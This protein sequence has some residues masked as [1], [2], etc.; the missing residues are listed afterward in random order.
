MTS[1]RIWFILLGVFVL[2]LVVVL[3]VVFQ[4]T[5][6]KE[7]S[8]VTKEKVV[9]TPISQPTFDDVQEDYEDEPVVTKKKKK[10]KRKNPSTSNTTKK[11]APA[12][13]KGGTLTIKVSGANITSIDLSGCGKGRQRIKGG[14]AVFPNVN[15]EKCNLKFAPSGTRTTVTGGQKTI[16]CTLKGGGSTAVCR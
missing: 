5:G 2:L 9:Q 1:N 14:K 4:L 6:N 7:E 11:V 3:V 15:V 12:A 8:K 13:P 16:T 10:K